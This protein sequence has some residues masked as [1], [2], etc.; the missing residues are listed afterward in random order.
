MGAYTSGTIEGE[1]DGLLRARGYTKL[2]ATDPTDVA[3]L[4]LIARRKVAA[5]VY[6]LLYQPPGRI[7]DWVRM[8]D[9]DYDAWKE[10]V[11]AGKFSLH[12]ETPT[13]GDAGQAVITTL[14]VLPRIPKDL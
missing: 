13:S 8:W 5:L 1:M 6:M 12:G 11:A 14:R 4:G 7:P 2:P 3:T 10:H 9:A